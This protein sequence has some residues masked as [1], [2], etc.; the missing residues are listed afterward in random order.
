MRRKR[1]EYNKEEK[2]RTIKQKDKNKTKKGKGRKDK[3]WKN[4][5]KIKKEQSSIQENF[6]VVSVE[7]EFSPNDKKTREWWKK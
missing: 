1:K 2:R 3:P 5:G 7:L 4:E 6:K